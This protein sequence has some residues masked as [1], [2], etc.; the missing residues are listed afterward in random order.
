ME[1]LGQFNKMFAKLLEMT[2][3]QVEKYSTIGLF[4]ENLN[5]KQRD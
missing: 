3:K 5:F 2:N 4:T 1:I